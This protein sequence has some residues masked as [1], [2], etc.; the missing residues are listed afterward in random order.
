VRVALEAELVAA[1][2]ATEMKGGV[3]SG[4]CPIRGD[5]D[6]RSWFATLRLRGAVLVLPICE[7]PI[8]PMRFRRWQPEQEMEHGLWGIPALPKAFGRPYLGR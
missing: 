7:T 1:L 4:F 2:H 8:L 3:V 6:L 5:P